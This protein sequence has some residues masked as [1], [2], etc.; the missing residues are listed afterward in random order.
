MWLEVQLVDL[1]F[2]DTW[3]YKVSTLPI[4]SVAALLTFSLLKK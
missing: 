4:F 3:V 1:H 2:V